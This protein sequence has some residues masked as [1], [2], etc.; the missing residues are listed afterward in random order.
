MNEDDAVQEMDDLDR[1]LGRFP[2]FL[3]TRVDY[4]DATGEYT[5][6][7]EFETSEGTTVVVHPVGDEKQAAEGFLMWTQS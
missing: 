1:I 7:L 6:G 5:V 2:R 4:M 3:G